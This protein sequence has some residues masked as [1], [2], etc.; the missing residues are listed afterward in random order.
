MHD[1]SIATLEEVLEHYA[2][3]GRASNSQQ[4]TIMKP[5]KLSVRDRSDL[6]AFL[7]SLTDPVV[8]ADPRWSNPWPKQEAAPLRQR[9]R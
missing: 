7:H 5:L 1:G 8:I 6:I 2:A 3:G 9:E 4:S